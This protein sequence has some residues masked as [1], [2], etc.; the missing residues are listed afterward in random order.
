VPVYFDSSKT[1]SG[2]GLTPGGARNSFAG[3]SILNTG[4]LAWGPSAADT[5]D[6]R[7]AA[8]SVFNLGAAGITNS[9][10]FT[11]GKITFSKY[12]SG[13]N[14][15]IYALDNFSAHSWV[16]CTLAG[17]QN[18]DLVTGTAADSSPIWYRNLRATSLLFGDANTGNTNATHW[19][20]LRRLENGIGNWPSAD[21][22]IAEVYITKKNGDTIVTPERGM[23]IRASAAKD[24][25][26]YYGI[27]YSNTPGSFIAISR[28]IGGFEFSGID[29]GP[30][31]QYAID[32]GYGTTN[33]LSGPI[34]IRN[35]RMDRS[36][37]MRIGSG[38]TSRAN[39][40]GVTGLLIEDVVAKNLG[41]VF[42]GTWAN[43]FNAAHVFNDAVIRRNVV[44]GVC[45]RFS[46][47]GIYLLNCRTTDGSKIQVYE[48]TVSGA[49]RD[50]VWPDGYAIY[51]DF[52]ADDYDIYRNYVWDSD[53]AFRNNGTTGVG[54]VRENV[55]IAKV[56]ASASSSAFGSNDPNDVDTAANITLSY[57]V[58]VGF[59]KFAGYQ[60]LVPGS[61][62][63][64]HHN[65]SV[66]KSGASYAVDSR[67]SNYLTLD[68]NNFY[69][70]ATHW[71]DTLAPT[72]DLSYLATNKISTNPTTALT[73]GGVVLN[74]T[75]KEFNYAIGLPNMV[76]SGTPAYGGVAPRVASGANTVDAV[77]SAG[78][79]IAITNATSSKTTDAVTSTGTG[80][81]S[82][83]ATGSNTTDAVT[84]TGT[85]T[86]SANLSGANLVDDLVG[87]GDVFLVPFDSFVGANL[88]DDVVSV[89]SAE[90]LASAAGSNTIT[91]FSDS[92]TSLVVVSVVASGENTTSVSSS[93]TAVCETLC[94]G[95]STVA[96]IAST[97][98]VDVMSSF[99]GENTV[100]SIAS[101]GDV[102]AYTSALSNTVLDDV[103]SS[104]EVG[105]FLSV[106]GANTVDDI[107]AY[108]P[109][110]DELL[111]WKHSTTRRHTPWV[112]Q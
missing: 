15:V 111:R 71:A 86:L 73:T 102:A 64:I 92:V 95:A 44:A 37:G 74:P 94:S 87:S 14:P 22:H 67:D 61:A 6:I 90:S 65:V 98:E 93:G 80:T 35:F 12:G 31:T 70:Y 96:D 24:P 20:M 56:G 10:G 26:D 43:G 13:A 63:N 55:A 83:S 105:T 97:G 101:I 47:G 21:Y 49:K 91:V 68:S 89:G 28:P 7:V 78:T 19:G 62:F 8:N 79:S 103:F 5:R 54:I 109:Y 59:N 32:L 100:D 45:E 11:T 41:N 110:I 33:G 76:W 66:A 69:G 40:V 38:V 99:I 25:I 60:D 84:S 77:T 106:V 17:L 75:D 36:L 18:G 16:K 82:I 4:S 34:V 3:F 2:D 112:T 1:T 50:N 27:S 42:V 51:T 104:G 9:G 58:S 39:T 23:I 48:N 81:V 53:L 72:G 46:L 108:E 29:F 57:N 107:T 85:S 88:V 30:S 52:S